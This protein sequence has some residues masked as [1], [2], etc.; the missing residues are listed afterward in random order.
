M[1]SEGTSLLEG[2]RLQWYQIIQSLQWNLAATSIMV[3]LG[4]S[5]T[6]AR[7]CTPGRTA[8]IWALTMAWLGMALIPTAFLLNARFVG[9]AVSFSELHCATLIG[10]FAAVGGVLFV[11]LARLLAPTDLAR[12]SRYIGVAS[13][14]LG[15]LGITLVCPNDGLMHAGVYH[16]LPGA[17]IATLCGMA[18]RRLIRW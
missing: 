11:T 17:I 6:T 13:I 12:V 7:L 3:M 5:V 10:A 2:V 18:A 8:P 9:Y 14:A 4:A 1:V 16:V 15:A